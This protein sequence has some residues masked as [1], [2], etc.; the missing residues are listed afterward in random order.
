MAS[1]RQRP[2]DLVRAGNMPDMTCQG[3]VSQSLEQGGGDSQR[4][5]LPQMFASTLSL[6]RFWQYAS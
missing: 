5:K 6:Q 4:L 2:Q 1:S 3:Y